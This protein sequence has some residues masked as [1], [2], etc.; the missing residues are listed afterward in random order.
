MVL[1]T[2]CH[3]AAAALFMILSALAPLSAFAAEDT[4]V[5]GQCEARLSACDPQGHT[6]LETAFGDFM[7]DAMRYVSGADVALLPSGD[8]GNHLQ[9]G[10]IYISDLTFC[11]QNDAALAVTEVTAAELWEELE[12][13]ISHYALF[14][15]QTV[16]WDSTAFDGFLQVSGL[17]V[18]Y[19][20]TAPPGERI[21][22][23]TLADGTE[24]TRND[25]EIRL[26]VVST[27]TVLAGAYDYS[28]FADTRPAGTEIGAAESYI[29]AVGTVTEPEDSGRIEILGPRVLFAGFN[30]RLIGAVI[31][32]I[33]LMYIAVIQ[34]QKRVHREA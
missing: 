34:K 28:V 17:K 12:H 4:S 33:G 1:R 31:A 22:L 9:S 23:L 5:I 26:T 14:D 13:S 3:I 16:D 24:L 32:V 8:L 27:A 30:A 19:N 15:D 18:A 6:E 21:L 20:V 11:L 29:R 10:T 2:N 25:E 7:A